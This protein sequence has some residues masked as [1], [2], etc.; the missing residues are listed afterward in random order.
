M[1]PGRWTGPF[2]G[3]LAPFREDLSMAM[4][5][6][7]LADRVLISAAALCLAVN[8]SGAQSWQPTTSPA[9]WS[10]IACSADG[11]RIMAL[12]PLVSEPY[13]STDSGTTWSLLQG[14]GFPPAT[15]VAC[16]GDGTRFIAGNP[17]FADLMMQYSPTSGWSGDFLGGQG[18]LVASSA[19]GMALL[20]AGDYY[21]GSINCTI[22]NNDRIQASLD[23][24]VSFNVVLTNVAI[25]AL[26]CSASG[27]TF[28][29]ASTTNIIY[30]ST[31]FGV[32]WSTK[33]VDSLWAGPWNAL[34]SSADGSRIFAASEDGIFVSTTAGLHWTQI[35]APDSF[36]SMAV[37]A[38]GTQIVAAARGGLLC[39]STNSGLNRDQSTLS[40]LSGYTN[41]NDIITAVAMSADGAAMFAAPLY[42]SIYTSFPTLGGFTNLDFES[43]TVFWPTGGSVPFAQAFPGWTGTIG[44]AP[45]LNALYNT[46]ALDSAAIAII[47]TASSL[48]GVVIGGRHTAVLQS[49]LGY[50]PTNAPTTLSQTGLV[51]LGTKSLRFK[52]NNWFASGTFAVTLGWQTLSLTTLGSGTNYILYGADVSQWAAKTNQLSFT[53]LADN[54]HRNNANLLLD[55]IQFSSQPIPVAPQISFSA[56]ISGGNIEIS[57]TPSGGNLESSLVLGPG[58][59]WSILGTKNPRK[60]PISGGAKFFRVRP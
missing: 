8:G 56:P 51:P 33:L 27:S 20:S 43:T 53:V 49:G 12:T 44:G 60:V 32:N 6:F 31:N 25:K 7:F 59:T 13:A 17:N 57:W 5:T 3:A 47:D 58:A 52:V 26:A 11:T 50:Y 24:G 55:D 4:N 15:D 37:S 38:D 14:L 36:Q 30:I 22:T 9:Q 42:G 18:S 16:N 54:P 40:G 34:A 21:C 29:A 19:S 39:T 45:V 2:G 41:T 28:L 10:S 48:Q 23:G 46:M 1:A 35:H